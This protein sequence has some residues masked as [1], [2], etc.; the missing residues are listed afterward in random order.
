MTKQSGWM[1]GGLAL[2]VV[3]LALAGATA[4]RAG[5]PGDAAKGRQVFARCAICHSM[6]PGKTMIG[7]SLAGIVGRKTATLSGFAYSPAMK[8]Y[9]GSW[10]AARLDAFVTQPM[11]AVPG[12][13]MAFAGL[14]NPA[15]RAD[16]IAYLAQGKP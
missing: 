15:E 9:G 4:G 16:L 2:S 11:K 13:R 1:R 5:P 7:P 10:D 14:S 8:A 12:T 6:T 3:P